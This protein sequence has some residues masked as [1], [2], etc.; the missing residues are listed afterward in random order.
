MRDIA[1]TIGPPVSDIAGDLN[2]PAGTVQPR[3]SRARLSGLAGSEQNA[4]GLFG[5]LRR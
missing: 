3:R 4:T 2:A 1:G 5:W